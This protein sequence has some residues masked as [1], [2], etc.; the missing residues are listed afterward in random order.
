MSDTIFD[1][2]DDHMDTSEY[3]EAELNRYFRLAHFNTMPIDEPPIDD[4]LTIELLNTD[5]SYCYIQRTKQII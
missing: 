1:T 3:S 2:L 5:V 4:S